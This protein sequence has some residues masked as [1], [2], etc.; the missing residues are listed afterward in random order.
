MSVT[1]SFAFPETLQDITEKPSQRCSDMDKLYNIKPLES[2]DLNENIKSFSGSFLGETGKAALDA[3]GARRL[4]VHS[5]DIWFIVY[6][7]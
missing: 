1:A 5:L 4:Y 2:M 6:Y 3:C 7:C